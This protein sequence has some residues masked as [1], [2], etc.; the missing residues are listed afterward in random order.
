MHQL[1]AGFLLLMLLLSAC[2]PVNEIALRN[3]SWMYNEPQQDEVSCITVN[4]NDTTSRA[5]IAVKPSVVNPAAGIN[6]TSRLEIKIKYIVYRSW[7]TSEMTDSGTVIA[8]FPADVPLPVPM[9]AEFSFRTIAGEDC[10]LFLTIVKPW[11]PRE[12]SLTREVAKKDINAAG[13]FLVTDISGDPSMLAALPTGD[14]L[15]I[16]Y[17]GPSTE[18]FWVTRYGHVF[19]P[20]LPPFATE[21]REPFDYR[22]DSGFTVPCSDGKAYGIKLRGKGL[23]FIRADSMSFEGL[24]LKRFY[25]GY[26]AV[27]SPSLMVEPLRYITS[28][29]E[30]EQ[31]M[32]SYDLKVSVDSFWI[33]TGGNITRGIELIRQY[34]GRVEDA[35]RYFTSFCEGWK[36][37]RGMIFIVFGPPNI[38]YRNGIKEEW[39]YGEARNYRSVHFHFYKVANPFTDNDYVLQRQP[40]FKEFWYMAVQQWRR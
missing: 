39:I 4:L 1:A 16:Q 38:V 33:A 19:P 8:G 28:G 15:N 36:T 3:H 21:L 12:I 9:K 29:K 14:P 18:W 17:F 26:P 30:Y 32:K 10:L 37:D 5:L 34:Y 20:A 11:Q 25:N 6:D 23:Y 7:N 22:T 24:S 27:N 2:K 40:N 35:N 31:L 13:W